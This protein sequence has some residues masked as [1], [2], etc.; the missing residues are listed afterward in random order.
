M[1]STQTP[2]DVR[3]VSVRMF[4]TQILKL[5]PQIPPI[6]RGGFGDNRTNLFVA[7]VQSVPNRKL[8]YLWN[9]RNLWLNPFWFLGSRAKRGR[10]AYM[11]F[12]FKP[13]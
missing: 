10:F 13:G 7:K 6:L 5:E 4:Y 8:L 1:Q 11:A 3:T 2:G 12:I 9:L